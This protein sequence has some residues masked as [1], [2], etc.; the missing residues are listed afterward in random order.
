MAADVEAKALVADRARDAAD[1]PGIL[2]DHRHRTARPAELIRGGQSCWTGADDD[3]GILLGPRHSSPRP[4]LRLT[5]CSSTLHAIIPIGMRVRQNVIVTD[6]S[7]RMT[8][9]SREVARSIPRPKVRFRNKLAPAARRRP[10]TRRPPT[11]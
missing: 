1:V 4:R 3:D 11:R 10:V 6:G 7:M 5:S 8:R 9:C 2:L